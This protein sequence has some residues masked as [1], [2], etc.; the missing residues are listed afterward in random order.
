M[1]ILFAPVSILFKSKVGGACQL[2]NWLKHAPGRLFKLLFF[3]L[4]WECPTGLQKTVKRSKAKDLND[5]KRNKQ[6]ND[7]VQ[8]IMLRAHHIIGICPYLRHREMMSRR[9]KAR[10]E[11]T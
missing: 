8:V 5:P 6:N 1:G 10:T 4:L 11:E 2:I 3:L 9:R 7:T